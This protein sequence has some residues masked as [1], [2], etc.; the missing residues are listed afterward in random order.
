MKISTLL[1]IVKAL[2]VKIEELFWK[3]I[4]DFLVGGLEDWMIEKLKNLM[5]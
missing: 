4:F 3:W 1:K 5:I 2:D